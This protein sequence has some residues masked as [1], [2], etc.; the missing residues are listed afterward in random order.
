VP[1][2]RCAALA[3]R[4]GADWRD[5]WSSTVTLLVHGDLAGK[6]VTDPK[7]GYS[8]KLVAAQ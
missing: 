4:N 1:Q 2:A 8:R 3:A 7:R 6:Q 5:D